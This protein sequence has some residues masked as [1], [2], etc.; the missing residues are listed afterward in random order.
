MLYKH[1][2]GVC[3]DEAVAYLLE[4]RNDENLITIIK[5]DESEET[6]STQSGKHQR[7]DHVYYKKVFDM[8]QDFDKVLLFGPTKSKNEIIRRI[9]AKK[10]NH[11]LV[12]NN[13]PEGNVTQNE[14]FEFI[15]GFFKSKP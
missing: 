6:D 8:I 3:V 1:E 2:I 9:R 15:N 5:A 11:I 14:K 12:Q 4:E 13:N 10:L 7:K